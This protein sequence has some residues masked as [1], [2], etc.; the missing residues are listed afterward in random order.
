ML[1]GY[2][3]PSFPL[4]GASYG[5]TP[6]DHTPRDVVHDYLLRFAEHTGVAAWTR[7][8]TK[9]LSIS[10][11]EGDGAAAK[12]WEL[13]VCSFPPGDEDSDDEPTAAPSTPDLAT[14]NVLRMKKLVVAT[15]LTSEPF[16]PA[17]PGAATF[18]APLSHVKHLR[19]R[20]GLLSTAKRIAVLGGTKSAY[21]VAYTYATEAD[22]QVHMIN[23]ASGHGP[24]LIAPAYVTPL[25]K[26]L[27]EVV[28]VR[29]VSWV[30]PCIWAEPTDGYTSI[31]RFLHGTTLGR[32]IVD[33]FNAT[34]DNKV[35]TVTGYDKHPG[36]KKF[37]PWTSAFW[38]GSYVGSLTYETDLS[39]LVRNGR[40]KDHVADIETLSSGG[41]VHLSDGTVLNDLDALI[42][43]TG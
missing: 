37:K 36:I 8:R 11:L 30:S 2:E 1:G 4:N 16:L 9:V 28:C 20:R 17:L 24:A 7:L 19:Q 35:N 32:F 38:L 15:G 29:A 27:A 43:S 34:L 42:C 12:G 40:V 31:R 39:E 3:Y 25:K 5:L 41:G 33:K 26:I 22:A 6:A 23:R 18:G 10:K 21:D 13:H 14:T